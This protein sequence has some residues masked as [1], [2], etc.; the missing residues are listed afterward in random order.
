MDFNRIL[1]VS[2]ST[3]HF[4]LHFRWFASSFIRIQLLMGLIFLLSF[5]VVTFYWL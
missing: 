3:F 5:K 4:I 2:V 1:T